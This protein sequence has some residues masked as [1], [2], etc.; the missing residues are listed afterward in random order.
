MSGGLVLCASV[1]DLRRITVAA[2]VTVAMILRA[3]LLIA[4]VIV[5]DAV[6]LLI[7]ALTADNTEIIAAMILIAWGAMDVCRL[8][9][10][11]WMVMASHIVVIVIMQMRVCTTVAMIDAWRIEVEECTIAIDRMD[12]ESPA[13]ARAVDGAIEILQAQEACILTGIEH[14]AKILIAVVEQT[15]VVAQSIRISIHHIIHDIVD[16][17][18]EVEVDL[19]AVIILHRS[20]VKLISHT[21]TQEA[22]V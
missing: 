15:V 20:Q 16:G 5:V 1:I 8:T 4:V 9:M 17:I 14:I 2:V 10:D 21:V 11:L 13:S 19:I 18:D 3:V 6:V 22:C 7:V 12:A